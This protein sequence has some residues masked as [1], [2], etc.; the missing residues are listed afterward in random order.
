MWKIRRQ[1]ERASM[2]SQT[3]SYGWPTWELALRRWLEWCVREEQC[4]P[5]LSQVGYKAIQGWYL[6]EEAVNM[7]EGAIQRT[8]NKLERESY[9]NFCKFS[10]GKCKFLILRQ[11]VQLDRLSTNWLQRSFAENVAGVPA[12]SSSKSELHPEGQA[13][14]QLY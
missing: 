12:D 10:T 11:N 3:A 9:R 1:L 13:H 6:T 8:L 5:W 4:S 14:P 2:D 7:L